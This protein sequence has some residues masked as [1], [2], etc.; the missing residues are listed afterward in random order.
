M[1][2][3]HNYL[4]Q[5]IVRSLWRASLRTPG[6]IGLT[7]IVTLI[8][9]TAFQQ[10]TKLLLSRNNE[11]VIIYNKNVV[12]T[13]QF[14]YILKHFHHPYSPTVTHACRKWRLKWVAT[15][16]LGDINTE[17]WSTRMGLGVGLTTL[18]CKKENCWEASKKFSG[19]LKRRSRPK[20]GC[21]AKERIIIRRK[22]HRL[23]IW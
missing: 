20:L 16:P 17:A 1:L 7:Y 5:G 10:I 4:C 11:A 12:L 23:C 8:M 13:I 3:I 14:L 2:L 15:L 18:P 6:M 19:I 22:I 9:R 21:G